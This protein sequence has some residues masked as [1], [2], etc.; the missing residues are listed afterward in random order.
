[1]NAFYMKFNTRTS[2][3]VKR[4][5]SSQLEQRRFKLDLPFITH[6]HHLHFKISENS[7]EKL[8]SYSL[9]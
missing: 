5:R 9:F 4:A 1:M 7:H 3:F 8:V 2:Y 6:I